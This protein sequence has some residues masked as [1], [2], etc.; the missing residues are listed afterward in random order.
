MI[1]KIL[2]GLDKRVKSINKTIKMRISNNIT[3][4]KGTIN[5]IRKKKTLDEKN[6]RLEES[7]E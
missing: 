3:D 5:E 1:I 2:D 6:N 7:E 4:I